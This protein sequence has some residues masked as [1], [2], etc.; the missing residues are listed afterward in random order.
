MR[1]GGFYLPVAAAKPKLF[2]RLAGLLPASADATARLK[3]VL[4]DT[5]RSV[6]IVGNGLPGGEHGD[7]IDRHDIVIRF[8]DFRLDGRQAELGRRT[9]LVCTSLIRS[10]GLQ[11]PDLHAARY[12]AL[13]PQ[14]RP[15]VRAYWTEVAAEAGRG[16][17]ISFLPD[18]T[19]RRRH[20]H[21]LGVFMS[22]GLL[23][24]ALLHD[25][26]GRL[27][28]DSIFGMPLLQGAGDGRRVI[29]DPS[30]NGHYWGREAALLARLLGG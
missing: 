5:R 10:P 2:A 19:L 7:A 24:L 20:E 26:R 3:D 6:A 25:L 17:A 8:N 18:E 1:Q 9:D 21:E 12:G 22:S 30:H 29:G 23:V 15:W 4:A 14:H 27:D 11:Q 13:L 28:P 16:T